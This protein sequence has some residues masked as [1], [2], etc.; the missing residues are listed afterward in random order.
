MTSPLRGCRRSTSRGEDLVI[1]AELPGI[2]P[3][4]MRYVATLK[5]SPDWSSRPFP[6]ERAR[7]I[8][9]VLAAGSSSAAFSDIIA[10]TSSQ[11]AR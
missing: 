11:K 7:R 9:R 10:P 5:H 6:E 4:W 8:E 1:R 2:D 3:E